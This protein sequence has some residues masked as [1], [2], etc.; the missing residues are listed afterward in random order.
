MENFINFPEDR[1]KVKVVESTLYFSDEQGNVVEVQQEPDLAYQLY[2][3]DNTLY[4]KVIYQ[5]GC[6]RKSGYMPLKA[7]TKYQ[8]FNRDQEVVFN[9]VKQLTQELVGL[10]MVCHQRFNRR[11]NSFWRIWTMN[12]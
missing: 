1:A 7:F 6:I 3:G 9:S 8:I 11:S 5:H 4:I 2:R 12:V 10:P